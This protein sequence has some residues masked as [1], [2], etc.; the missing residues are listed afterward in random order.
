MIYALSHKV[1]LG[2]NDEK[3][4]I[5]VTYINFFLTIKLLNRKRKA[6]G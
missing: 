3:V 6:R 5:P 1:T 4:H 2:N